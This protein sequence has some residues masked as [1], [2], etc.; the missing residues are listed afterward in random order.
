MP[1]G[2]FAA[3]GKWRVVECDGSTPRHGPASKVTI[4]KATRKYI[5]Y[6]RVCAR[7]DPRG[8]R[9]RHAKVVRW[10]LH[11]YRA[12]IGSYQHIEAIDK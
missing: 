5:K 7:T 9:V 10:G 8:E 3:L 4:V 1:T 2:P 11:T 6:K 12:F